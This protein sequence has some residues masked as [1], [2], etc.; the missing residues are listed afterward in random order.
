MPVDDLWYL[1]KKGPDGKRIPSKRH[2]R[3]KRYRARWTDQDGQTRTQLYDRKVDAERAEANNRA[4]VSRGAYV[5]PRAGRLTFR[6]YAERWQANQ[7]H[8][9][10]TSELVETHLRR[11]VLPHLGKRG[12]S[13][14]RPTDVQALV[15]K[16]SEALAPS[17]VEVIYRYTA[18]IFRAAV[19]DRLIAASPCTGVKLPKKEPKRVE[20]LAMA[21]V[22][23]VIAAH[24][25]RFQ[26]LAQTGAN[27]GLRSGEA[28]GLEVEHVDFLR[29]TLRVDQQLVQMVGREPFLAPPK[30]EASRRTVPIGRVLVDGLAAHL[31]EF[32]P[33]EVEIVDTC[34]ARPVVRTARL[35]FGTEAGKPI[36]RTSYSANVWI[37]ARKAACEALMKAAGADR[38]A[39]ELTRTLVAKLMAATFHD[40]RHLFAS[41]LIAHGASVKA[42]Q[43]ALGHKSASETLDTY[44][45]LWPDDDD[46]SRDAVDLAFGGKRPTLTA[47]AG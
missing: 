26:A 20:P 31:A 29:R 46:R 15:R 47:V 30:T 35:I 7:V 19:L 37:P 34:G 6:K 2:G 38:A 33:T 40:L 27:A 28:F 42:V 22:L 9:G 21:S 43:A 45:H 12:L 32:G 23:A 11:H 4:D 16:L 24:P 18:A 3:G 25:P 8:R 14:I 5:D 41:L 39:V 10:T 17:T 1:T 13:S 44:S 36:R